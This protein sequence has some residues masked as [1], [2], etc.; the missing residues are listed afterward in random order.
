MRKG[1]KIAVKTLLTVST[2]AF[3]VAL[4]ATN[5][6]MDN[7]STITAA[8]DQK[9]YIVTEKD[10][11][12]P[13]GDLE[14]Y[15]SK[16]N[17]LQEV[18]Q[19]GF[20][21]QLKE[22]KEG[23][24]LLKNAN[25]ALPLAKGSKVS[26]FGE[27]CSDPFYGASGSGGINT[28]E[29]ISWFEAF[30]GVNHDKN[31]S[32]PAQKKHQG[33][34]VFEVNP[35]L[36]ESYSTWCAPAKGGGWGAPAVTSEYGGTSS[37]SKV[38]IGD[39]PWSVIKESEGGKEIDQ[40]GDAA[41][42]IIKRTGGEGYD[43][44]STTSSTKGE[45][46]ID[47]TSVSE[48]DCHNGDYLQLNDNE[49]SILEG[50]KGLKDQGK[51]KKIVLILNMASTIEL[52]FLKDD[53]LGVDACVFTGSV[54]E[55]GTVAVTRLLTGEYN[56][57]GGSSTTLWYSNLANPV[58]ANFTDQNYYFQYENYKDF[59]FAEMTSSYQSSYTS[60]I[61]YQEGMYL[62]YKYTETRYEDYV[63]GAAKVGNYDYSKVVAYP[64]GYGESYTTF[65]FSNQ[66]V[67]KQGNTYKLSVDVTN[68]GDK[69][70]KTP[71]QVYVSKPYGEYEKTNNI[72]VP[73]VELV[74]FGKTSELAAGAKETVTIDIDEKYL[75]TFDAYGANTYVLTS[76]EYYLTAARNAHDAINNVLAKKGY[77]PSSTANRMDAAGD[78]NAVY[79]WH[80][81]FD[82]KTYSYSSATNNPISSKFD[83][84]DINRYEGK[85]DNHV[86]YYDRSN[87]EGTV[88]LCTYENGKLV[89]P[90]AKIKMT[91]AMADNM[92]NQMSV[93]HE[94]PKGGE[95]PTYGAQNGLT[96]L[97]L[98]DE[99]YD[100]K[101]WNDLLDQLTWEETYQ[102]LS[103]GR[104]KSIAL[105]SVNK[106]GSGDEN[107]PNG[108]NATYGKASAGSG[109]AGPTNPLAE[110]K[111]DPDLENRLTSTGFSSNGVL[112]SSWNKEL[113]REVGEQIGEEGLWAGI[114]GWLGT[115]A[116]IIRTPY[117]GRTAEYYS[118]DAQLTGLI[119]SPEVNGAKTKGINAFIK[120][121]A[122]N[123]SETAR[124]G[125]N[126]WVPEQAL[127]QNYFRAFELAIE[128]GGAQSVMT[129]FSRI[130]TVA[131][132]NS[133][134]FAQDFLRK[135]C[136]LEGIVETD[137]AG[138]MTDGSHGEAYV[139]RM[140]NV[141]TQASDLN[142]YNYGDD[143]PD[144]TGG[145][146]TWKDFAP[147]S[148][149]GKGEYGNMGQSMRNSAHRILYTV[150]H[151]NAM[152]NMS[153]NIVITRVTP[154]WQKTIKGVD[155]GL[156]IAV[157]ASAAWLAVEL[158]V[159]ALKKRAK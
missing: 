2:F 78:A 99:E 58:N 82:N 129:S 24:V 48:N 108:Y 28:S 139:S 79:S 54:G 1:N 148:A 21:V 25:N 23:A 105:G 12:A 31:A 122:I 158:I 30:D 118:E 94:I 5:I 124:H 85:G 27:A 8:L 103:N 142:E 97:D 109:F 131:V 34:K 159:S 72:Q 13:K 141:Y 125:V 59:G 41:I 156:G 154:P 46:S 117:A 76:G 16:F 65:A 114:S 87:W 60:Y 81:S 135:E 134:V 136:G 70:G 43:L 32:E 153:N 77:T 120:H 116:N 18:V 64:F 104:H 115:G 9:D 50:L 57:S 19:N 7:A 133:V 53:T 100:S 80:Q 111:N 101:M 17:N 138:D 88:K 35:K 96:L 150:L 26:V 95:Y 155:L 49:R 29:A 71:V 83:F 69:A 20:D 62:G 36:K 84:V 128:E 74:D 55:V 140:V 67:T 145:T 22:E 11:D 149:G 75:S 33:E 127:R 121:C 98:M 6:M 14:Y 137:C 63:T 146:Y 39:A 37:N 45:Y 47:N 147:V 56:F 91:Q 152:N 4:T 123:E 89:K 44:P 107:G 119:V 38:K 15:K 90:Y 40:Y 93:E 73:S 3:A 68:T 151:S 132:A 130:G 143:V 92:R 102:L 52:D 112:A 106:P 110:R 51:V 126:C 113:A 157:G 61:A 42:M 66:K 10:P 144:Y 86:D